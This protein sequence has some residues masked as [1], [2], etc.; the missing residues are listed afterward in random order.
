MY[1]IEVLYAKQTG[2]PKYMALARAIRGAVRNAALAP[3]DRL[4]PVRGL[5]GRIGVTPGT[6][7]RTYSLLCDEGVLQAT[8]GRGTFVAGEG[9][10]AEPAI[11]LSPRRFDLT[12]WRW[13]D[14]GQS[15]L[16]RAALARATGGEYAALRH[17]VYPPGS[18]DDAAPRAMLGW[19]D[20]E[21]TGT[22]RIEDIQ[23]THGAQAAVQ[24]VMH[25]VLRGARPVVLVDELS[26]PVFARVAGL[27]RAEVVAV[28]MDREGV[29]PRAL[30]DVV[31]GTGAQLL[32][33]ASEAH[34]PTT[35]STPRARREAI[36][37]VA[38]RHDL[39]VLDYD[40][41]R[42]GAADGPGYRALLPERG[43]HVGM[44][45][46]SL[47]PWLEAGLVVAPV[48]QAARLKQVADDA[49][50]SLRAPF[51]DAQAA[52]LDK[53]EMRDVHDRARDELNRYLSAAGEALKAH[54]PVWRRDA[55]HLW[56]PLPRGW[57]AS[58]FVAAASAAGVTVSPATDFALPD[59]HAPRAVRIA[60]DAQIAF[61]C[62]VHAITILADLLDRGP[63]ATAD[64]TAGPL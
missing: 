50:T 9:I 4:P 10:S 28:P 46:A 18:D 58:G 20:T 30:D 63:Q 62:F 49:G 19:L 26:A 47:S 24:T 31:S 52:L 22:I 23:L 60:I 5:A 33:T 41:T 21:R 32:C 34:D 54:R 59:A 37:A 29:L 16:I 56:L 57:T 36:A 42:T 44:V 14:M 61:D 17:A 12:A 45:A 51:A 55:A 25:A 43:W 1:P 11:R 2:G 48:G 8:V 13:P 53:V 15:A 7:A 64:T 6:V 38:R 3:G 40:C 39:H 27:L 35:L